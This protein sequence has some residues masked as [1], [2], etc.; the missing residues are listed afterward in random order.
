MDLF[1]LLLAQNYRI[2]GASQLIL[3][4]FIQIGNDKNE[5]ILAVLAY[6]FIVKVGG[7]IQNEPNLRYRYS[8]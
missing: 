4:D 8:P 2:W 5:G 7:S 6:F 1:C 3:S